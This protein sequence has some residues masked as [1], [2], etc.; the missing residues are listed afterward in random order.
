MRAGYLLFIVFI[1]FFSCKQRSS[2]QEKVPGD[3]CAITAD[4]KFTISFQK[5]TSTADFFQLINFLVS[6]DELEAMCPPENLFPLVNEGIT[7]RKVIC[8]TK[9]FD[10]RM[11][12]WH[13]A[14][15]SSVSCRLQLKKDLEGKQDLY[16]GIN[17]QQLNF[18]NEE[19]TGKAFAKI[20]EIG[21][22]DPLVKWNEYQLVKGK[23]RIYVISTMLA[24][25]ESLK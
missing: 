15:L 16:D 22:D 5:D 1:L 21:W 20:Q 13:L 9:N 18:I 24:A 4:K 6:K 8:S 12:Y 25:A 14:N 11:E 23:K 2:S 17:L 10:Y 19:E 7:L 3:T